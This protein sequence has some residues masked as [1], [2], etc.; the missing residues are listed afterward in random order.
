ML[1]KDLKFAEK[2]NWWTKNKWKISEKT[3]LSYIMSKGS[4]NEIYF[5][6]K[7]FDFSI[8]N[9]WFEL[10]KRDNFILNDRRKGFLTVLFKEKRDNN[11]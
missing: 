1:K 11:L 4:I 5:I 3:K 7:N 8:L 9:K 2:Y 6:F 10:I